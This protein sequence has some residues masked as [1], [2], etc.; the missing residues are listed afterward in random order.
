MISQVE[1][2]SENQSQILNELCE[3]F[4]NGF[5]Q[6]FRISSFFYLSRFLESLMDRLDDIVDSLF[7]CHFIPR[8]TQVILSSGSEHLHVCIHYEYVVLLYLANSFLFI[9]IGPWTLF[10]IFN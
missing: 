5:K 6:F 2:D 4:F 3:L 10:N 7:L 9:P 8:L 1:T